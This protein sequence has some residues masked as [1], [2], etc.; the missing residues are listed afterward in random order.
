[1]ANLSNI[2]GKFVVE[3]TTGYVGVGT[4][5]PNYPIEVLN[6]SAEIALNSSGGSIYRLRSD[7]TDS[8]RINKNGVGDRLVINSL[9][10][11]TFSGNVDIIKT[12]SDVAGELRIGG[13]LASDNLPFGKINF[14]NT[15][16]A[17]SQTNDVLAYI[18]GE[19]TGSSN[20]GELTFATSN[21][22]APVERLRID[23]SGN[24]TFGGNVLLS[25]Y[26]SVEGTSG[27]TGGATDRWIG[28]DGTAGTWFYNVPT[29]SSHLF[30]INNSNVLTLNGT[31]ATFAGTINGSGIELSNYIQIKVDDA[32]I[33]WTNSANNDYW[34][35]KRDASNNFICDHYNG[36][37]T[38]AALS[39]DSSQNATFAG[40][41]KI[42]TSTT[43]TPA[44]NADDLVI[45]KGASESGI[46]LMSTAAASIRFGDAANTSIG[47]LEY[48]HNSNYMRMIVNN[49]EAMRIDS[50]GNINIGTGAASD[51]YVRIYNASSGD[52][53]AGYQVYNG[54]N[55]DLN[56]YTN[57]LFGNSTF[58]SRETFSFNT[59]A[60]AKVKILNNGNVG[61]GT[62][63]PN[64]KLRIAGTQGNPA[65]SGSTSTGFLSL[66]G[67]GA[68]H[69]LMMGV[70]NVSPF[71]SWIQAQD[72][73]NHATNYNLLLNP[74][75]GNVGIGTDSPSSFSGYTNLSLKAGSTGN[76]LDF[77]NSSGT[78]IGAIVT[79]GSDDVIL[80]ASGISRNLIFKTDNAGTFSEKMRITSGGDVLI[81]KD[82]LNNDD[83]GLWLNNDGASWFTQNNDYCV[84]LN[85]K[86][87]D[88]NVMLFTND[89]AGAGSISVSGTTTA[90]NTSSDYRLKE[91]LQ[92]FNGLDKV[93]KIPVYDFKWKTDESRSYGVMAHELQ[94][95]LPDAVS[96]KKDAEEMQGVDYSKIVPLLVKSIQELKAEIELLK[97][98]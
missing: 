77:F 41:V 67:T 9:G 28:G 39:F 46:T 97:N 16:A 48:N 2:N 56:I 36:S 95:V 30:G 58:F 71:G 50:S 86:G 98:K 63:D 57:P 6:A 60:G 31:G 35:W 38:T 14:A 29:G 55:L 23:S 49:A 69:G 79:D 3:Q 45:D 68:S 87:T 73:S 24:S 26:L 33:Y 90:F 25:G 34:R 72:K 93:S 88:G 78:R 44:V 11:A 83:V 75:G 19:K 40:N 61:I 54:S 89:Q 94:E 62:T 43:G 51:T 17:N 4:T 53:T 92:D 27:N 85:R 47:S 37:S 13:I 7:S 42:G 15:A 21:N 84:G 74:N 82:A 59:S 5:D 64:V 32:E 96:G 22:S 81:G 91:D 76:N 52:I 70:Q 18:A 10:N 8:F 1:M 20:R 80:E 65:T 12:T 66:Y